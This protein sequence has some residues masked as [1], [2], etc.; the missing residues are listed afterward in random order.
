[1]DGLVV[2]AKTH[3]AACDCLWRASQASWWGWDGG[4]RPF[5][6]CWPEDY[7]E[8]ARNGIKVWL[9]A[10]LEPWKWRQQKPVDD[11][12]FGLIRAKLDVICEKG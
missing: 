5:F 9:T 12:T 11:K 8:K 1:M 2:T 4:S 6:W 7:Q 3:E 10:H